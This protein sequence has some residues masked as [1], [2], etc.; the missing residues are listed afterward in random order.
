MISAWRSHK[1]AL[2]IVAQIT[3]RKNEEAVSAF[4]ATVPTMALLQSSRVFFV[5]VVLVCLGLSS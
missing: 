1:Q 5:S 3:D 2:T 4:L